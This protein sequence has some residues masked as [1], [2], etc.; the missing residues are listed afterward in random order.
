[1]RYLPLTPG[2]RSQMLAK[3]GVLSIDAL[4]RDVPKEAVVGRYPSSAARGRTSIMCLAR[5]II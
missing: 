4:F 1:M 5:W 2:D 3:I